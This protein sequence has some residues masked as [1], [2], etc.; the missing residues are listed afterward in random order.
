[1][2]FSPS[3]HVFLSGTPEGPGSVLVGSMPVEMVR[4]IDRNNL[5]MLCMYVQCKYQLLEA[6][7]KMNIEADEVRMFGFMISLFM[8]DVM[9]WLSA[10]ALQAN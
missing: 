1:M 7:D 9:Y 4:D 5:A 8:D 10:G 6:I 2:P 3:S